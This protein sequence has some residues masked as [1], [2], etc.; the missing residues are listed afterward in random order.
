MKE[1]NSSLISPV[2]IAGCL[3]IIVTYGIRG[4]FGVFQIPIENEFQWL[5]VEFSLAIAIQNLG[6]GIGAPIFGALGEKFGDKK[7][8]I[9]GALCYVSGLVVSTFAQSPLTHQFLELLIGFGI[10]GTGMGMILASIHINQQ[11]FEPKE[12]QPFGLLIRQLLQFLEPLIYS[13]HLRLYQQ[14]QVSFPFR[15]QQFQTLLVILKTD[16]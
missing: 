14:Q 2:L 9:V 5:R 15:F 12:L 10:A 11:E 8:I 3:I 16:E 6:W 4:S 1:Y 13:S 7:M